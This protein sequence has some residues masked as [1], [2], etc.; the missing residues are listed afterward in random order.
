LSSGA[1]SRGRHFVPRWA[2][3]T[4]GFDGSRYDDATA[5]IA[6][7]VES[8]FQW[9]LGVWMHDGTPNM[10]SAGHGGRR[11]RGGRLRA[12]P[13]AA[14]VLR[15]A[16]V[17]ELGVDVGWSVRRRARGEWWTNRR[18]PMAYALRSFIA[19]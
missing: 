8:G 5:L 17:G 4:L 14:H 10:G 18:K 15:P 1:S 3:I 2:A 11:R 16:E 13:R 6:T 12:V 19:R 9:P 7:D